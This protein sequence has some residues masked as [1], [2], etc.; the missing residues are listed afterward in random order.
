MRSE[1]QCV[2]NRGRHA[3]DWETSACILCAMGTG[4]YKRIT[5]CG[6]EDTL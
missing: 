4:S 2:A 5:G 6:V 3:S 1:K